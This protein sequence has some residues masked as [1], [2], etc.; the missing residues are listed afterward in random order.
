MV[1]HEEI[2]GEGEGTSDK[3]LSCARLSRAEGP[4]SSESL[5]LSV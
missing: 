4:G 5:Y 3:G 2:Q 1:A